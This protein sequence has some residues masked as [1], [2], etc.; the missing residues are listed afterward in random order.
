M[1]RVLHDAERDVQDVGSHNLTNVYIELDS[2]ER[3]RVESYVLAFHPYQD[4][5]DS[6]MRMGIFAGRYEDIFERRDGEWKIA[7]RVVI[8]DWSRAEFPGAHWSRGSWQEGGFPRGG[9]GENDLSH[10]LFPVQKISE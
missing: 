6:E 8:G 7:K 10:T 2:A 5:S 1:A 4:T 9:R 3:A